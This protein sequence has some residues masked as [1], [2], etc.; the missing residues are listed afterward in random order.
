M[1]TPETETGA[2][3]A[4]GVATATAEQASQDAAG[5][6]FRAELA[7]D[8]AERAA[9]TAAAAETEAWE[10]RAAVDQLRAEMFGALD[11]IRESLSERKKPEPG[12]DPG[13]GSTAVPAPER[14]E[15]APAA[16]AEPDGDKPT[17]RSYGSRTW[18]GD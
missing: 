1:D 2:A 4:A 12:G 9:A 13:D 11:E 15:A 3:F 5:A 18:F 16:Q 10:A 8:D 6:E 7:A 17:R 14:K